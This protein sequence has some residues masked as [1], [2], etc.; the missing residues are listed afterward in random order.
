MWACREYVSPEY[1][2]SCAAK[3][4]REQETYVVVSTHGT[5]ETAERGNTRRGHRV[6]ILLRRWAATL[7]VPSV[8]LLRRVAAW[9]SVTR[10]WWVATLWRVAAW[11]SVTR[12]WWVATWRSVT[13]LWWVATWRS[14]TRLWR[15]ATLHHGWWHSSLHHGWRHSRC[16]RWR[17]V[18]CLIT[19]L[20][21]RLSDRHGGWHRLA[22]GHDGRGDGHGDGRGDGRGLRHL[23]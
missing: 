20:R 15:V 17:I 3:R 14:V 10:L 5:A 22:R 23:W 13:R 12:L 16:T 8:T 4:G 1:T 7:R 18:S 11:R 9:R 19:P 2:V 21:H 6:V